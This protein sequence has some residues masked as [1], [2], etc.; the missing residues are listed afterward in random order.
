MPLKKNADEALA[1]PEVNSVETVI[2]VRHTGGA[3]AFDDA[4]DVWYHEICAQADADCA[5]EEMNA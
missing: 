2:V 1:H 3:A 5:P 4:R